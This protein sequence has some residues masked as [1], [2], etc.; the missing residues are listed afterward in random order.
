MAYLPLSF[1]PDPTLLTTPLLPERCNEPIVIFIVP[2]IPAPT[3]DPRTRMAEVDRAGRG[4]SPSDTI[5]SNGKFG[6]RSRLPFPSLFSSARL[7]NTRSSDNRYVSFSARNR[8]DRKGSNRTN[9][10]CVKSRFEKRDVGFCT[11][12][13]RIE[14]KKKRRKVKLGERERRGALV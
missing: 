8:V 2:A 9:F 7:L 14:G 6:P 5:P 10:G 13:R 4:C 3:P 1:Y 11:L 12:V